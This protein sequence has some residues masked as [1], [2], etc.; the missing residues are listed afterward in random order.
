MSAKN[1][2]DALERKMATLR[3]Q[4]RMAQIQSPINGSVDLV[5][6]K[7]G[8][9]IAPGMPCINVVNLTG[10]KIKGELAEANISKVKVGDEIILTFPDA[11]ATI[12]AKATFVSKIIN[13]LSRTFTIEARLESNTE[14]LRPGMVAIMKVADYN[15]K[16]A[17]TIP[18]NTLQ[19]DA[20]GNYVVIANTTGDKVKA[21][22]SMVET[23]STYQ[24]M[25]EVKNGLKEGDKLIVKGFQ[26]LNE[27]DAI[28]F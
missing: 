3:E 16:T 10:L 25:V 7:E 24:G 14:G 8:Q 11:N 23:G 22:K 28:E 1:N 2:K 5:S 17:I 9:A 18:I 4:W 12:T 26:G 27:G 19:S 21:A 6:I 20:N 15:N 13:P